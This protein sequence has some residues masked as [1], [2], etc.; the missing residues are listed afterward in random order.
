MSL[1]PEL[2][3]QRQVGLLSLQPGLQSKLQ[4]SQAEEMKETT[5]NRDDEDV[6]E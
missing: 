4:D 6:I 1:I 5:E 3:R 2:R